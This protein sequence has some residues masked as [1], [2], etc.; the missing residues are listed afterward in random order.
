MLL[1]GAGR[2]VDAAGDAFE[3]VGILG[4]EASRSLQIEVANQE[5][6]MAWADAAGATP[7]TQL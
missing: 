7:V 3:S 4:L 5:F 6:R 1:I 2:A